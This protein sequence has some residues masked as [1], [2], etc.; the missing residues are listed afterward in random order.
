MILEALQYAATR[1]VTPKEFRPH[2]RYSVNLWARANRCAKAWAEHEDNSRQFVLQ[3]A[4]KLKQRRTAVVLGSGLLRD[5]PHDA[6]VAMF[7][8]V[9]LVDLVHLASVQ[10]KLRLNSKK[11]VR[12][13]NR[14]LSGFD[15]IIAGK[16][17]EPLDF[18]RRVP[19]LDFVVSA[20]LLS[21]IGTGARH[22]L[23]REKIANAPDDLLPKLIQ[24]HLDAL[25][26]L[27]CKVCLVTDTSFDIIGKNGSLHQHED[28]LHGVNI[29]APPAA[30]EWP[31]APLGE[32]SRDYRIVHHV[33]ARELT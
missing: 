30:W 26:G 21:Q 8:T 3:S 19:Y 2:I 22:R 14:D 33:I 11:N 5:V 16:D 12:V 17:P 9:V 27:P 20:N 28:L 29:P 23:E 15:E 4:R 32:E 25:A 10:A 13:A 7:D 1:A 6:L 18:L 24:T 31:L